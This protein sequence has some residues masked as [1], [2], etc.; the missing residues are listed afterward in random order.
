MA[1]LA[2][3]L[4]KFLRRVA[5]FI[6]K[7]NVGYLL[8]GQVRTE[9]IGGFATHEGLSGGHGIKH[10]SLLTVYLRKGQGVDS[11]TKKIIDTEGK[12]KDV[13]IGFDCVLKIIKTKK[14]NSKS[15]LSE[16]HIPYY[17]DKGYKNA[18]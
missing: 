15:E 17:F 18:D 12:K 8:I 11:P 1:L 2:K 14:S 9:G 16:L 13:K 10:W 7:G 6:Y 3:K 5:P 4:G